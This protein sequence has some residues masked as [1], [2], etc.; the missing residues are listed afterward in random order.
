MFFQYF[1]ALVAFHKLLMC[2]KVAL[3]PALQACQQVLYLASG[4]GV[5]DALVLDLRKYS[6]G[7][8]SVYLSFMYFAC[9][10]PVTEHLD[11]ISERH[12]DRADYAGFKAIIRPVFIM[13]LV[14]PFVVH[15]GGRITVLS[16]SP[17]FGLL[18]PL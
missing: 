18:F 3:H 6:S 8:R 7:L 5:D 2:A 4:F 1:F 10:H 9:C 15:P 14:A 11:Q 17:S 13:M 12:F 16:R